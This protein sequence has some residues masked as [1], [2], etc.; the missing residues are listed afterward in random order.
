MYHEGNHQSGTYGDVAQ[1]VRISIFSE[2]PDAEGRYLAEEIRRSDLIVYVKDNCLCKFPLDGRMS[3][4]VIASPDDSEGCLERMVDMFRKYSDTD[5]FLLDVCREDRENR[6]KGIV[7]D[8][9][10]PNLYYIDKLNI[11]HLEGN[12]KDAAA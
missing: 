3:E 9:D 2:N 7:G 11:R 10:I 1:P 12:I 5:F 6:M 8:S 4:I